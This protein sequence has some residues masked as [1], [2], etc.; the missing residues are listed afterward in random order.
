MGITEKM[1]ETLR[2]ARMAGAKGIVA[3]HGF[4]AETHALVGLRF[5]ARIEVKPGETPRFTITE[6][7]HQALN[8]DHRRS[9]EEP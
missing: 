1:R 9:R 4:E 2:D 8:A 7:G 3:A 6:A 5:L